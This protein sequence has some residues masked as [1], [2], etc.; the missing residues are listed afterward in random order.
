MI[1]EPVGDEAIYL[2]L[3][4]L[5]AD[6]VISL[7][8]VVKPYSRLIIRQKLE[9]AAARV[10][11]SGSQTAGNQAS[12]VTA[13][14]G[15]VVIGEKKPGSQ[16]SGS[17]AD[18][19]SAAR[20]Q[21]EQELSVGGGPESSP[22]DEPRNENLQLTPRQQKELDFWLNIYSPGE[23]DGK[24]KLLL[25]PATAYYRDSLFSVTVAN[26]WTDSRHHIRPGG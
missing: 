11:E 3:D 25:N 24:F 13:G 14:G 7:N 5:A 22:G 15:E 17:Q 21:A 16:A 1:P 20:V 4:E 8:G 10:K 12:L 2:F 23:P 18:R 6:G 19:G 9:E 26:T